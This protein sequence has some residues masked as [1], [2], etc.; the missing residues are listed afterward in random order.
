MWCGDAR[1]CSLLGL[2]QLG[3]LQVAFGDPLLEFTHVGFEPIDLRGPWIDD[4][5][6]L[7]QGLPG[8]G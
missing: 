2:K 8:G 5:A 1:E 7:F 6:G 3:D 4:R